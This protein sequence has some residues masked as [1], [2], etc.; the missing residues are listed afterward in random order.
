MPT[1]YQ[2]GVSNSENNN[3]QLTL[4]IYSYSSE[5]VSIT[6]AAVHSRDGQ[7]VSMAHEVNRLK[8]SLDFPS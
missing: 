2:Q 6:T 5:T 3:M 7:E 4:C 1:V 8:T